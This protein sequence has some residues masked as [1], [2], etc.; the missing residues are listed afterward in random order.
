MD[1]RSKVLP[2]RVEIFNT[3]VLIPEEN[4][5]ILGYNVGMQ[6]SFSKPPNLQIN[7]SVM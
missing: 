4:I 7:A 5:L 2:S 3:N 1:N 6:K